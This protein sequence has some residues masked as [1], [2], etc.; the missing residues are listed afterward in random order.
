MKI[1]KFRKMFFHELQHIVF[2]EVSA[3][4][5]GEEVCMSLIRIKHFFRYIFY[6]LG[7]G[8]SRGGNRPPVELDLFVIGRP[9]IK[10]A[11]VI[12]YYGSRTV[13]CGTVRRRDS[14]P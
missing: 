10:Y 13:R 3:F 14:S 11:L 12:Q 5:C 4:L 8:M 6:C 1:A 9:V 7:Q 2:P